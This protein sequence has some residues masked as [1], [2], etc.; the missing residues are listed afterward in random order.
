MGNGELSIWNL[1]FA[2]FVGCG[3]FKKW[4]KKSSIRPK[5]FWEFSWVMNPM[6]SNPSQHHQKTNPSWLTF[7]CIDW[8][9]WR[10]PC[11][12][13]Y[14]I[15]PIYSC[16]A[17]HP[18]K[19]RQIWPGSTTHCSYGIRSVLFTLPIVFVSLG[20]NILLMEEILHQLIGRLSHYLQGFIH[21]R[22]CRIS[23][24][25][26]MANNLHVQQSVDFMNCLEAVF[27]S[28]D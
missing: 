5:S 23:S 18:L 7:P 25:N 20:G 9:K 24:I 15:I 4:P 12:M 26:S 8:W 10:D 17:F 19:K 16:L 3:W 28:R 14:D 22:W 13:A 1:R 21:P 2:V 6:G 27:L 11:W